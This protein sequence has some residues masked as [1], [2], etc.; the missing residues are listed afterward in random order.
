M[1]SPPRSPIL[2]A[3]PSAS[4]TID[5]QTASIVGIYLQQPDGTLAAK[6]DYYL[7]GGNTWGQNLSVGDLDGD[8]QPDVVLDGKM[9]LHPSAAAAA[10]QSHGAQRGAS[11]VRA[12]TR[13][14][15]PSHLRE[16]AGS[17][18]VRR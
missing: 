13:S 6:D 4:A 5:A 12:A 2:P 7:I 15:L 9:S 10:P 8:G 18:L 1:E 16:T 11:A 14:P 3:T 17:G